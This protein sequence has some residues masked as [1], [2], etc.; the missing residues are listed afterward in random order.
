[1]TQKFDSPFAEAMRATFIDNMNEPRDIP[2]DGVRI[3]LFAAKLMGEEWLKAECADRGLILE[4]TG[5]SV[6]Q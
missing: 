3:P 6:E 4:L 1:M 2:L 5:T